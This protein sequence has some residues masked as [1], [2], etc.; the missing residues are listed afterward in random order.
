[1]FELMVEKTFDA[2]HYLEGYNGKCSRMH[3][4]TYRVQL[5]VAGP[6]LDPKFGMLMDFKDMKHALNTVVEQLD[7]RILNDVV[8]FQPTTEQMAKFFYDQLLPNIP[9]NITLKKVV[10]WENPTNCAIYTPD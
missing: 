10:L 1:M 4:H 3:G 2:A 8:K 9:K 5:C 6:N 7:H